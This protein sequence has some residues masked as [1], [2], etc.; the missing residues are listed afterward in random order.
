MEILLPCLKESAVI[1]YPVQDWTKQAVFKTLKMV[2]KF[3]F[4]R[5][6]TKVQEISENYAT[7]GEGG[8]RRRFMGTTLFKTQKCEIVYTV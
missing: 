1:S 5:I 3:A 7:K 2:H 6:S 4:S 8:G